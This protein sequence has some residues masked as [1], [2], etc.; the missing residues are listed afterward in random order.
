MA[1]NNAKDKS[2]R[3]NN[4][5]TD[6]AIPGSG[7]P[8]VFE[9]FMRPFDQFMEPLFPNAMSSYGPRWEERSQSSTSR[10]AGTTTS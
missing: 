2:R 8:H 3:P 5:S 4:D 6:L 9:E 1:N 10:T 7:L